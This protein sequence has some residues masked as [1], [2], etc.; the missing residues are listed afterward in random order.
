MSA[1]ILSINI[2][3]GDRRDRPDHHYRR[4]CQERDIGGG[5]QSR[6]LSKPD[7]RTKLAELV[8]F[9]IYHLHSLLS[10]SLTTFA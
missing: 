5:R 6:G 4:D 1:R 2:H 10:L 9:K 3:V 8:T 7:G